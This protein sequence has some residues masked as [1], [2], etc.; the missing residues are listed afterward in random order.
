MASIER[1]V[2]SLFRT[3]ILGYGDTWTP[4]TSEIY[5]IA[6]CKSVVPHYPLDHYWAPFRKPRY[7]SRHAHGWIH[8]HLRELSRK[9][10]VPACIWVYGKAVCANNCP[11]TREVCERMYVHLACWNISQ[12]TCFSPPHTWNTK[13]QQLLQRSHLDLIGFRGFGILANA[14]FS[15]NTSLA[16]HDSHFSA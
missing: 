5:A 3:D 7:M 13:L 10:L 15:D 6:I 9:F 4:R 11:Y 2:H 8:N 1:D 16:L 12:V 14:Y